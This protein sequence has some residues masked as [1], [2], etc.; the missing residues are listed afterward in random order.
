MRCR[1]VRKDVLR[2]AKLAV[3]FDD[4]FK[5]ISEANPID[6]RGEVRESFKWLM[7]TGDRL[8]GWT[9][10]LLRAFPAAKA[11]PPG[12]VEFL[13]RSAPPLPPVDPSAEVDAASHALATT[14]PG[15]ATSLPGE[16]SGADGEE[17]RAM[18]A[19]AP[20]PRP[21]AEPPSGDP[22]GMGWIPWRSR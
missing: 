14:S 13:I 7:E 16:P 15:G 22:L 3:L 17:S 4:A 20:R 6:A 19:P 18:G 9:E 2:K 12:N 10:S 1:L 11:D 21:I 8:H 5:R